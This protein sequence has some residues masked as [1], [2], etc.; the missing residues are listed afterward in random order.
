MFYF[1][2]PGSWK[3]KGWERDISQLHLHVRPAGEKKIYNI[4]W[5]S[6]SLYITPPLPPKNPK[7]PNPNFYLPNEDRLVYLYPNPPH[8]VIYQSIYP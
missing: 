3:E 2:S 7:K 5:N 6:D 1:M 8:S 4:T